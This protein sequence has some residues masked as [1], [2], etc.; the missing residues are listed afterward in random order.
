MN[1]Q[2]SSPDS[3][4]RASPMRLVAAFLAQKTRFLSAV[5]DEGGLFEMRFLGRLVKRE[6]DAVTLASAE[7]DT[8]RT[9]VCDLRQEI[10]QDLA[11]TNDTPGVI[12][13]G[14]AKELLRK[15]SGLG[16]NATAHANHL[17]QLT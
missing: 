5:R 15:L 17:D 4:R 9:S 6:Q 2:P 11:S 10:M 13:A 12:D 16:R 8:I 14:E 7:A 3:P 1:S